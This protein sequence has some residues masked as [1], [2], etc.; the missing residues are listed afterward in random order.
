[1]LKKRIEE[2][3]PISWEAKC[4]ALEDAFRK[5]SIRRGKARIG[6]PYESVLPGIPR[7]LMLMAPISRPK[8]KSSKKG[9]CNL[10][11]LTA[12]TVKVLDGLSQ[13]ALD[14]L[15]YRQTALTELKTKLRMLHVAAKAVDFKARLG[16]P[17]KVQPRKIACVVAQ[18]YFSLTGERPTVR[19]KDGEKAYGPF[20]GLLRS[21]FDILGVNNASAESQAR[22]VI[23]DWKAVAAK[24]PRVKKF[25]RTK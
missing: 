22:A 17:K 18:H 9:L 8:A 15:N 21:V 13:D 4:A 2:N 24:F 16:Q 11:Q 25:N 23:K 6:I 12:R 10:E 20:L 1:M 7:Q 3:V 14:S 5:L 19:V